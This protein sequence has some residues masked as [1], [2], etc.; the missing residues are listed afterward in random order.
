MIRMNGKYLEAVT[1]E[2]MKQGRGAATVLINYLDVAEKKKGEVRLSAGAK[3]EKCT[4]EKTIYEVQFMDYDAQQL[5]VADADYEQVEIP[6]KQIAGAEALLEA[7]MKVTIWRHEGE[8]VKIAFPP[9]VV[10][11]MKK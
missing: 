5:V 8:I 10:A 3:V 7:G 2:A 9:D 4:L 1:V 11:K 6:Q